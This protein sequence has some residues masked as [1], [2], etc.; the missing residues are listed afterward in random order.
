MIIRIFIARIFPGL[1]EEF[2]SK[3]KEVSVPLTQQANGLISLE[4]GAS[5]DLDSNNF[6][7]ISRWEKED[8]IRRFAGEDWSRAF[9]PKGMEQYIEECSV[10]HFQNID[11]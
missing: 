7:M 10:V 4:I 6:L 2:M 5:I 1:S 3:L 11:L 8:D 9:I